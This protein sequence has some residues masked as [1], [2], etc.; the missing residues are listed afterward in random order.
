MENDN[1]LENNLMKDNFGIEKNRS[2]YV[3]I[4]NVSATL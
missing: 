2:K 4:E 1:L 3:G